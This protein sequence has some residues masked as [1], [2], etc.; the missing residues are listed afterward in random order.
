MRRTDSGCRV[1]GPAVSQP[2]PTGALVGRRTRAGSRLAVV[3][4][5]IGYLVLC[6][7]VRA[8]QPSLRAI[9][10]FPTAVSADG[11]VI[12]GYRDTAAGVRAVRW[13]AAGETAEIGILA[14]GSSTVRPMSQAFGVSADGATVVGHSSSG[15]GSEA[16]RWTPDGGMIGL[17][18]LPWM[19]GIG[20]DRGTNAHA[21][22]ADGSVVV[23]FGALVHQGGWRTS[24]AFRWTKDH[25]MVGVGQPLDLSFTS[26]NY[27]NDVSA[28]GSVVVGSVLVPPDGV[29]GRTSE[30]F[31]WTAEGGSVRLGRLHDRLFAWA[32]AVSADG[33]VV[34][35]DGDG[36]AFRWTAPSGMVALGVLP[37]TDR[38]AAR[39]VSADGAVIVGLAW[40]SE[41]ADFPPSPD[42][43][44]FIWD[45]LS[46]MRS[47]RD[48]LGE[49]GVDVS[50]WQ[51]EYATGISAD[52][53]TV[54]GSDGARG[55][56]AT[57]PEPSTSSLG[58]LLALAASRATMR[59]ARRADDV[60][61]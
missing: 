61:A 34:V 24:E 41:S 10:F 12:V 46:G 15:A 43:R 49:R 3:S 47:L 4:A 7:T 1:L 14:A 36:E 38:T 45:Q 25:G 33:S 52:G 18:S 30:P 42:Y 9:D 35:G 5:A 20:P 17:G 40:N 6:N 21:A 28:D 16:F 50:E 19:S 39:D 55:W 57:I 31:R 59:P 22:S 8:A 51:L 58:V 44:V 53:S 2:S 13:T 56:V 32:S 26:F 27:A 54:V 23:G 11:T 37:G 29:F 48:M 60:R